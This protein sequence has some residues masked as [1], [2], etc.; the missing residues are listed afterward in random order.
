MARTKNRYRKSEVTDKTSELKR[1]SAG[2]YIRL[3][4]ERTEA[5]RNKSQSLENQEKLARTFAKQHGLT[6]VKCYTD[7]EYSGTNFMRPAFQEMM[8]DI[9]KG[10]IN[11]ILIRDLSRL[12]RDYIEMGRLIDKVFPFLGVRFISIND[13][14]DT[15]SGLKEKKSFEVEIKNLVNDMYSKDISKKVTA[16]HIQKASEGYFISGFAPYGYKLDKQ[17]L[18]NKLKIDLTVKPILDKVF[19]LF[20]TGYSSYKVSDWL[21]EN[22]IAT[23]TSYRQTGELYRR[24]DDTKLWSNTNLRRMIRNQ[25]YTGDL[26][27]RKSN[28]QLSPDDYIHFN[29]AHESYI[30]RKD[31]ETILELIANRKITKKYDYSRTPNRYRGLLYLKG[32]YRQM[33]REY[34]KS[35]SKKNCE[36]HFYYRDYILNSNANRKSVC[37]RENVLDRIIITIIQAEMAKIGKVDELLSSLE[38]KYEAYIQ[39][40]QSKI[41][42]HKQHIVRLR[43]EISD[44]YASY[45]LLRDSRD[46]YISQKLEKNRKI[47]TLIQEIDQYED[48][49]KAVDEKYNRQVAWLNTLSKNHQ[50]PVLSADLLNA[51]IE[52]I[53][54]DENRQISV[55]FLCQIGSD[56]NA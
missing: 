19:E 52:R 17:K 21:N 46:D 8:D 2:I 20:L 10:V 55:T 40:W 42:K 36:G 47:E 34:Q 32:S 12:G 9:K 15:L 11:C 24:I 35:K 54:I 49:L 25:V 33:S 29:N 45:S 31:Y 1:Y 5:C 4:K 37:I 23:P 27:Q 56:G 22:N 26:V 39:L 28:K 44:L 14:L 3:S 6:V 50:S 38:N 7:Y 30:S 51:L 41:V 16:S 53:E 48:R 18:G 13:N 43:M